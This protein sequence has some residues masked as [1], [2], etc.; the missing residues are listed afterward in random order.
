MALY[1]FEGTEIGDNWT[2]LLPFGVFIHFLSTWVVMSAELQMYLL[3]TT[4]GPL[5]HSWCLDIVTHLWN[6]FEGSNIVDRVKKTFFSLPNT[7]C[8]FV[9]NYILRKLSKLSDALTKLPFPMHSPMK[10]QQATSTQTTAFTAVWKVKIVFF[11]FEVS[12][13]RNS[14]LAHC[15]VPESLTLKIGHL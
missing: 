13:N 14:Y 2:F 5:L 1:S 10:N 8:H 11:S 3:A 7:F 12:P 15:P 4:W 9:I 6:W